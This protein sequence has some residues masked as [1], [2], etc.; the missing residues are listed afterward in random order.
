MKN[1]TLLSLSLLFCGALHADEHILFSVFDTYADYRKIINDIYRDIDFGTIPHEERAHITETTGSSPVYG[2]I[3]FDSVL[4]ILDYLQITE[5]DVFY[6]LGSGIGKFVYQVYLMSNA[7]K[8][9]GIELSQ[10]RYEKA[11]SIESKAKK[12]YQDCFK[13]ENSMRKQFGKEELP[14]IA[15][16]SIEYI[17]GNVLDED[18]NDA[19]VLYMDVF[20]NT[21]DF[22]KTLNDKLIQLQDGARIFT[23]HE[24]LPHEYLHKVKT[25]NIPQSWS[26]DQVVYFYIV[27]RVNTHENL[28]EAEKSISGNEIDEVPAKYDDEECE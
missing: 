27:D 2:E 23:L 4:F 13:F 5:D 22:K 12:V 26:Q 11:K 28:D 21:D 14:K 9:V 19:T 1:K 15:G 17:N 3:L 18:I 25:F 20:L 24:L 10:T 16:K 7:K 6:D 8:C